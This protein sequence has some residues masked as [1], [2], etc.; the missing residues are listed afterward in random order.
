[1]DQEKI[2]KL[3][4]WI[5][6]FF[7]LLLGLI[8]LLLI[9]VFSVFHLKKDLIKN[10]L[11]QNINKQQN[12]EFLFEEMSLSPLSHLP[13]LAIQLDK[14]QYKENS[15]I[16]FFSDTLPI[17]SLEYAEVALDL[18]ELIKGKVDIEK[19]AFYNGQINIIVYEDNSSNLENALRLPK[20][21]TVKTAV[22][23]ELE[24]TVPADFRLENLD[25]R[26]ILV[27]LQHRKNQIEV[28]SIVNEFS[29]AISFSYPNSDVQLN[30]D[31]V[32]EYL[33]IKGQNYLSGKPIKLVSNLH[34]DESTNLTTINE[35]SLIF[36]LLNIKIHGTFHPE[37]NEMTDLIFDASD[38]DLSLL[39]Y[40]IEDHILKFN[41]DFLNNGDII[42][43]GKINGFNQNRLPI[44]E[45]TFKAENIDLDFTNGNAA[46]K[47]FDM[48]GYFQTGDSA[49]FSTAIIDV[50][51]LSANLPEG[52][53][54]GSLKWSN[55]KHPE[56]LLALNL[57][58]KL[59][60]FDDFFRLHPLQNLGG[61]I[62]LSTSIHRTF[63]TNKNQFND[64]I[65][66]LKIDL[67]D[68]IFAFPKLSHP[69]EKIS[70][71]IESNEDKLNIQNLEGTYATSSLNVEGYLENFINSLLDGSSFSGNLRLYSDKM[72]LDEMPYR[73]Y[74]PMMFDGDQVDTFDVKVS[75]YSKAGAIPLFTTFPGLDLYFSS[76][77]V[78]FQSL[79]DCFIDTAKL[80]IIADPKIDTIVAIEN[81]NAQVFST[82]E[83]NQFLQN[84][85]IIVDTN[86]VDINSDVRV[87]NTN[88][89]TL[90]KQ[91]NFIKSES[92]S[93]IFDRSTIKHAKADISA[94]YDIPTFTFAPLKADHFQLNYLFD[95]NTK[96][97]F[98]NS[99]F[100]LEQITFSSKDE[101]EILPGIAL[102]NGD[103]FTE[104]LS[105]NTEKNGRLIF[106]NSTCSFDGNEIEAIAKIEF[107]EIL[108]AAFLQQFQLIQPDSPEELA[109]ISNQ[110]TLIGQIDLKSKFDLKSR[111][112]KPLHL[113]NVQLKYQTSDTTFIHL[114]EAN[115]QLDRLTFTDDPTAEIRYGISDISGE[116]D[117]VDLNNNHISEV[118]LLCTFNGNKKKL[119]GDFSLMRFPKIEEKGAFVMD[120]SKVIPFYE[121]SYNLKKFPIEMVLDNYT[122]QQIMSGIININAEFNGAGN[123][124][125][126]LLESADGEL[127]L[128]GEDITLYGIDL[129]G[130][131]KQYK[132]SQNFNL[133]DV[134]A[135]FIAGPVGAVVTKGVDFAK[136]I[137]ISLSR[138]EK[139]QIAQLMS[140]WQINKG[141]VTT[142]D[143]GFVTDL[144]RVV[145]DGKINILQDSIEMVTVSVVDE[146]GCSLISQSLWGKYDKLE[147]GKVNVLGKLLGAVVNVLELV[148]G[149]KCT[150]VYD[151]K[152]VHPVKKKK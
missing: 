93:I 102:I 22:E 92:S 37:N 68:V 61:K 32:N 116:I 54:N 100:Q 137:D 59:N 108:P 79:P 2:V 147:Y 31:L 15:S 83:G 148:A 62:N 66:D 17:L 82:N 89:M 70:G 84:T 146:K 151:G 35:G 65:N 98:N 78:Y 113:N 149:K 72:V 134:S 111:N 38:Q 23:N 47:D 39:S 10:T 4:K 52:S 7:F 97:E 67:E 49:D 16:D 104:Q 21:D 94:S 25:F 44:G 13:H 129:D 95:D 91:L 107:K 140:S 99:N 141:I 135:Y 1:M 19:V 133:V 46:I 80:A 48:E 14:V 36:D 43:K 26:N 152:L 122:D 117:I 53:L 142:N 30:L 12:G 11:I 18:F 114:K 86:S 24:E 20:K 127:Y 41:N 58:T 96:L 9:T 106:K 57:E 90:L 71:N 120:F 124:M 125:N 73:K 42:L 132:K 8:I 130:L 128:S 77:T 74:L 119:A 75:L 144:N 150:Q 103:F 110:N 81:L 55:F 60:G 56:I 33:N 115:I 105:L 88:L 5:K 51:N 131:L 29:A 34:F 3:F 136:L 145:V 28:S 85:T 138:N 27:H 143:V 64:V 40:L 121:F 123:D 45:L 50:K 109:G 87:E 139:T 101:P 63:D 6:R 112:F 126:A 69:F 118:S 76:S